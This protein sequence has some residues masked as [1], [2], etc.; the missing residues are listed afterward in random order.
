MSQPGNCQLQGIWAIKRVRIYFT[1][2]MLKCID[3]DSRYNLRRDYTEKQQSLIKFG[4]K[5][6]H[7]IICWL[8]YCAPYYP[9]IIKNYAK[10][11]IALKPQTSLHMMKNC[12]N[13]M[14]EICQHIATNIYKRGV[15][16]CI[17]L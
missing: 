12:K 1:K 15:S 8:K 14:F 10:L 17:D 5:L 16:I 11:S 2:A 3:W 4:R 7:G 6:N 9:I 13:F